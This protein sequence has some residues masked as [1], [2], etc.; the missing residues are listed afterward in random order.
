VKL[1]PIFEELHT[2]PVEFATLEFAEN[3]LRCEPLCGCQD[4]RFVIR[5][6]GGDMPGNA[7]INKP[8]DAPK[9]GALN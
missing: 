1:C 6:V 7:V 5:K 4:K 8:K 9:L 2:V 3:D